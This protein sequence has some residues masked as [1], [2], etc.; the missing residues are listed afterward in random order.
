MPG[1]RLPPARF[2]AARCGAGGVAGCHRPGRRG[3]WSGGRGRP[4]FPPRAQAGRGLLRGLRAARVGSR[5]PSGLVFVRAARVRPGGLAG[6]A[7]VGGVRA[8]LGGCRWSLVPRR[9]PGPLAALRARPSACGCWRA[10]GSALPRGRALSQRWGVGARGPRCRR[11]LRAA[12]CSP[13]AWLAALVV[14]LAPLR[15]LWARVAGGGARPAGSLSCGALGLAAAPGRPWR[16]L[17]GPRFV[18]GRAAAPGRLWRL[19]V[20]SGGSWAALAASGRSVPACPPAWHLACVAEPASNPALAVG[21]GGRSR[22]P[23]WP[24]R[25]PPPWGGR[26][27]GCRPRLC[28]G[29]L[30]DPRRRRCGDGLPAAP[31]VKMEVCTSARGSGHAARICAVRCGFISKICCF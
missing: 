28:R 6:Q 12:L 29:S 14:S 4:G 20:G 9:R 30:G 10:L 26:H 19:L 1:L 15:A 27:S 22:F 21:G 17:G 31:V 13:A 23:A 8:S 2:P 25:C 5:P 11:A 18:P 24:P 16:L 3:A 7:R